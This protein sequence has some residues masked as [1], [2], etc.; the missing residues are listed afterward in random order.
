MTGRGRMFSLFMYYIIS[1]IL[2]QGPP[3][4]SGFFRLLWKLDIFESIPKVWLIFHQK[5]WYFNLKLIIRLLFHKQWYIVS[6]LLRSYLQ[7][8]KFWPSWQFWVLFEIG[9][10]KYRIQWKHFRRILL[11]SKTFPEFPALGVQKCLKLAIQ[12]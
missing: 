8:H 9:L 6:K 7:I 11:V 10:K 4:Q 2:P 3:S 12:L 1:T 5:A